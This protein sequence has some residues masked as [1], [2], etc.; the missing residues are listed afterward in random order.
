MRIGSIQLGI[1]IAISGLVCQRNVESHRC[2]TTVFGCF[3][4]LQEALDG[5]KA[6]STMSCMHLSSEKSGAYYPK[7][8]RVPFTGARLCFFC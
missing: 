2:Y 4:L 1:G 8:S 7:T 6:H 5:K 3:T